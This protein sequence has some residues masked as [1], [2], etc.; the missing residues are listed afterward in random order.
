MANTVAG[1]KKA[2]AKNK[3]LHGE[4][5][6]REIGRRGGKM[7]N[8]ESEFWEDVKAYRKEYKNENFDKRIEFA[9]QMFNKAR[10]PY[11]LCNAENGHFNLLDEN[12]S[13]IMSFWSWTG[14]VYVPI[15]KMSE[16]VGIRRAINIYKKILKEAKNER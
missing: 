6:C 14:K 10:V 9:K 12:G 1:E 15:K 8:A 7:G 5:F 4:D 3:K 13:V 2:A 16:N 11:V